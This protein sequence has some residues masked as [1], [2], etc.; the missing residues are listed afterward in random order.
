MHAP[1]T[2]VLA[3]DR[4]LKD[5]A[6]DPSRTALVSCEPQVLSRT[7][8]PLD[9]LLILAT[10]GLWDV[11]SDAQAVKIACDAARRVHAALPSPGS[12]V[13]EG[14]G[15][16]AAEDASASSGAAEAAAAAAASALVKRAGELGSLDN[17]LV[18]VAWIEWE[19]VAAPLE[20]SATPAPS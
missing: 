3:G 8:S 18:L 20:P 17:V 2:F 13:R 15:A 10:D 7:L 19:G 6:K 16:R 14:G 12:G 4:D 1:T 5:A 9:R 11:V